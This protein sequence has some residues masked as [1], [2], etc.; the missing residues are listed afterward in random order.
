MRYCCFPC[1][2]CLNISGN[3]IYYNLKIAQI[4]GLCTMY[5]FTAK[6]TLYVQSLAL[7]A[8]YT[9]DNNI[10]YFVKSMFSKSFLGAFKSFIE[11]LFCLFLLFFYHND[12]VSSEIPFV[13]CL[14]TPAQENSTF[15]Q[16]C[17]AR[18]V[19][20]LPLF[21][22]VRDRPLYFFGGKG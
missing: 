17:P 18:L 15:S 19:Q 3:M 6:H 22:V 7:L 12:K 8:N 10:N 14:P 11:Q 2:V 4:A 16:F 9:H 5:A 1:N 21:K 13:N 20:Y